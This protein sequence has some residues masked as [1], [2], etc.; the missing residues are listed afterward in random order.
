MKDVV[1]NKSLD[2][3]NLKSMDEIQLIHPAA[4]N[5][6]FKSIKDVTLI[7]IVKSYLEQLKPGMRAEFGT[8]LNGEVL[9]SRVSDLQ[10][11]TDPE[12]FKKLKASL[13][14]THLETFYP[15]IMDLCRK[16]Y[17]E[18]NILLTC[19]IYITPN[20][21]AQCFLYHCDH[22]HILAY[23]IAGEKRWA[24]PKTQGKYV[25]EY[26]V[27]PDLSQ[28]IN[29]ELIQFETTEMTLRPGDFL[30]VPYAYSHR[31][32]NDAETP[33]VHLT[34]AEDDITKREVLSFMAQEILG[35]INFDER[36]F[37]KVDFDHGP[38]SD[39]KISG[40]EA[41]VT[42]FFTKTKLLKFK[43]GNRLV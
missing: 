21:N 42:D 40:T 27:K 28:Q 30:F 20:E 9:E 26:S 16:I 15:P 43:F 5:D 41:K 19:G 13:R 24:F 11:C 35:V 23:Q 22:Q 12:E 4:D 25:R 8:F 37:E 36:F 18:Q 7:D 3:K 1:I 2:F 38:L 33:S 17:Q 34:F 6:L 10:Q 39:L 31:A 32:Y 29:D 14:I